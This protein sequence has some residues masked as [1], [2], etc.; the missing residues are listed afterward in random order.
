MTVIRYGMGY[1][2]DPEDDQDLKFKLFHKP[3][4]HVM[5][6]VIDTLAEVAGR[7]AIRNQLEIGM[8]VGCGTTS[9]AKMR[10]LL[11]NYKFPFMPSAL[12]VYALARHEDGV[13]L[14]E[15]S[16]A[17]I[18]TAFKVMNRY[19]LIPEDSNKK[20]SFPFSASDNR[21]TLMPPPEC[22]E[23]AQKHLLVKYMRLNHDLDEI[24][25][26]LYQGMPVVIGMNLCESFQSNRVAKS[27]IIPKP[28]PWESFIGGHCM[29][30]Y[31]HQIK[32]DRHFTG[33]NSWSEQWGDR[34]DFHVPERL[35]LDP[36][37]TTDLW[38]LD[39]IN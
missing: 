4:R 21:W 16:G 9:A 19:G 17:I 39:L 18:R 34:G 23:A 3:Q 7:T 11:Q 31:G 35:I 15:D 24:R 2:K 36:A 38:A 22:M 6:N 12:G 27:G 13:P 20:W 14:T 10:M 37:H 5:P 26:A 29:L 33:R 1:L 30:L 25:W 32:K 28:A 8:C